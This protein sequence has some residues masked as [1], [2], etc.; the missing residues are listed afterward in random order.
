MNCEGKQ[1]N[2]FLQDKTRNRFVLFSFRK[3]A[4]CEP[5]E[6]SMN[7]LAPFIPPY[8]LAHTYISRNPDHCYNN[9]LFS[10]HSHEQ[11]HVVYDCIHAMC[12]LLSFERV[13]NTSIS[14]NNSNNNNRNIGKD[15][16]DDD[17][18]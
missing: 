11:I 6:E 13:Q 10:T 9:K 14:I 12:R 5:T 1:E 4:K 8:A 7:K 18:N 17:V 16:D 3:M 2:S 15:E